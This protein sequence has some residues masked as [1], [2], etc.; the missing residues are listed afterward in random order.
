MFDSMTAT[1]AKKVPVFHNFR[2]SNPNFGAALFSKK[3]KV[4][5]QN[6]YRTPKSS[7]QSNL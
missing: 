1:M 5:G 6:V 3:F 2:D 4:Q 7:P